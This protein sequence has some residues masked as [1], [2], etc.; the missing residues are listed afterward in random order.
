MRIAAALF[1]IVLAACAQP[2]PVSVENAWVRLSA[3]PGRPAAGYFTVSSADRSRT[4]LGVGS[5][6]FRRAELHESMA[7]GMRALPSVP[8]PSGK[9]VAF[10]PGG[11]HLMLFEVEPS[12]AP[13]SEMPLQ[14]TFDDGASVVVAAKVVGAA[15]PAP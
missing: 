13:G 7:G 9:D 2:Q 8:V 3:V 14:F 6:A 11:R 5:T 15:D 1:G 10:T 4:L 12:V